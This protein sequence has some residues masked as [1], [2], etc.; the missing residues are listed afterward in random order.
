MN[1]G[2][3]L[4]AGGALTSLYQ[5][6]VYANNLANSQ[7]IGFKRDFV[8]FQQRL[9]ARLES[10][11]PI[12]PQLMLEQLGGGRFAMPNWINFEQGELAPTG[13]PLDVA[14]KGEGFF[15]VNS[16]QGDG[17]ERLRFTR[18]GRF[19]L[20][21]SGE[22]VMAATGMQVLNTN[23]EPIVLQPGG[24]ISIE[25]TGEII[26]NGEI[27]ARLQMTAI[28]QQSQ[29]K[30][31]G[32]NLFH[33]TNT[34]QVSRQPAN[35]ALEQGFVESSTVDPVVDMNAVMN[36]SRQAQANAKMMQYHDQLMNLAINTMGRIA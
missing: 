7:T 1:Y 18:D 21:A 20:N 36:A 19:M 28:P 30:K 24:E 25:S 31:A 33:L 35:V 8:Y 32:D 11:S 6:D 14:I 12:D 27:V 2:L 4:A 13:R 23:D 15:V 10:H 9:P 5:Q 26:Q 29:L 22:M 3:Y 17:A 34:A 16:G